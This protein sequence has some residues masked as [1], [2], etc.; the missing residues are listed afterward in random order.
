V[1]ECLR[2]DPRFSLDPDVLH[3]GF[4]YRDAEA[5]ALAGI[6]RRYLDIG[7][8]TG[9]PMVVLTPTWRA[10]PERLIRAGLGEKDVNGDAVR[11]LD[12]IRAE[13]GSYGKSVFI[14]GLIG[15][16][17]DAYLP[18][19]ALS[20]DDAARFHLTQLEAL[21][22]A[23]ADF[24]IAE[25][26]PAASEAC[27]IAQA[28]A[29]MGRPYLLSFIIDRS[30][31]LLD[32]ARLDTTIRR[33]DG[34]GEPSPAGYMVNCVHHSVLRDALRQVAAPVLHRLIGYQANTSARAPHELE[35]LTKVE[36]E[37]AG[38]FAGA[39]SELH[40]EFGLKLLGGCCGTDAGHIRA[41]AGRFSPGAAV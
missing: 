2:R 29:G 5:E 28:M 21:A 14:G 34:A 15:P 1:V 10:G 37:D 30:A 40:R 36:T 24:L 17:G 39:L 13:Y 31:H 16:R 4:L 41:L 20:Q 26:L 7:R 6:Y 18:A 23:G 38:Q 9:L 12:G 22:Q 19:E 11:F 33:I 32:G 8:D 35:G 25:T 27:G 3:A